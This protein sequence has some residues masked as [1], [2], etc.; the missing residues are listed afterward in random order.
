MSR[1]KAVTGDARNAGEDCEPL[2]EIGVSSDLLEDWSLDRRDLAVDL[3]ETLRILTLQQGLGKNPSA[4]LGGGAIVHQGFAGK[5]KLFEHDAE[6]SRTYL[7]QLEMALLSD[8]RGQT[9]RIRG[10]QR[11]VKGQSGFQVGDFPAQFLMIY[12]GIY[13]FEGADR[14]VMAPLSWLL[15]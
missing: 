2:G 1:A 14:Q 8:L 7:S 9:F 13:F 6:I 5:V 10:Q 12:I 11:V 3:F 15:L 4:V